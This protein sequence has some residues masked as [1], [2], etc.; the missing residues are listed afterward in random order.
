MPTLA[1]QCT[2][3]PVKFPEVLRQMPMAAITCVLFCSLQPSCSSSTNM[4]RSALS[5]GRQKNARA[6]MEKSKQ[7]VVSC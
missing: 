3:A 6:G 7:E 4:G 1:N 2:F 5:L